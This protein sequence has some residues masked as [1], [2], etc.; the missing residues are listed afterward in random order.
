MMFIRRGDV[1]RALYASI[2]LEHDAVRALKRQRAKRVGLF[3]GFWVFLVFFVNRGPK[4][5]VPY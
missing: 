2:L 5:M 4:I 1:G 3:G